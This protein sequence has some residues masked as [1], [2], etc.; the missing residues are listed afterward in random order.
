MR[1][2]ND[3]MDITKSTVILLDSPLH[4]IKVNIAKKMAAM[5]MKLFKSISSN[6]NNHKILH[7][8]STI[9]VGRRND[10]VF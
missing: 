6:I 3:I 7:S 8:Y 5:V 10:I 4:L 9:T 2:E 1:I